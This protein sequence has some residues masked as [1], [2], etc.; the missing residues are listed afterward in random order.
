M[1]RIDKIELNLRD[2]GSSLRRTARAGGQSS[3]PGAVQKNFGEKP[4]KQA[5]ISRDP[6]L[7]KL[8]S[9][10][11]LIGWL[12]EKIKRASK[13]KGKIIPAHD[14]TAMAMPHMP[15]KQD[16]NLVFLGVDF[17]KKNQTDPN[18]I[19]GVLSHEWGHLV[20][21]F[22]RGLDPNRLT[23]EQVHALRREEESYADAYAGRLLH[24]IGHNPEGLLRHL[25]D[26]EWGSSAKYYDF[27][28]RK[29]IILEAFN[30][31]IRQQETASRIFANKGERHPL[32]GRLIG[33]A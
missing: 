17:A 11:G 6:E 3:D 18:L 23:W 21:D 13:Q 5:D 28:T 10:R 20:S 26:H 2:L 22:L 9:E 8:F 12:E 27:E 24:L 32:S 1:S 31:Q 14:I 33:V 15:E 29:A 16:G 7:M 4:P 19:A 25:K 30:A